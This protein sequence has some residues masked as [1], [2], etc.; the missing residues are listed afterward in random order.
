[1]DKIYGLDSAALKGKWKLKKPRPSEASPIERPQIASQTI[2]ADIMYLE[3]EPHLIS[4]VTPLS[5]TIVTYLNG[6]KF[7]SINK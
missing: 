6:K 7:E 4:V 5:L 2:I 3:G 1:M